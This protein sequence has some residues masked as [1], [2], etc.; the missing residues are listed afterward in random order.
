MNKFLTTK[1]VAKI[2]NVS[3]IMI[4]RLTLI[5]KYYSL[6]LE[7]QSALVK[8]ILIIF[9]EDNYWGWKKHHKIE[10]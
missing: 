6:N 1:E 5:R 2:F 7:N 8:K 4:R 10:L 9:L 3:E